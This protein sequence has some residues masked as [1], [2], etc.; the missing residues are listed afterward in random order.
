M[1]KLIE[2]LAS[3]FLLISKYFLSVGS[4]IGWYFSIAGYFFTAWL[5]IK[6]SLRIALIV[7]SGMCVLS[8]YGLYK[9]LNFIKG[10]QPIDLVV[11][12]LVIIF[13][14]FIIKKEI[15]YK[16]PLWFEQS[17]TVLFCSIAYVLLGL[18]YEAIAWFLF[19]IMFLNNMRMYYIKK[20]YMIATVQV[21]S[22]VIAIG[23]LFD[24]DIVSHLLR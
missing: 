2:A 3:I 18:K 22:A 23:K 9:W 11:I 6:L 10:I 19:L 21:L 12:I 24:Y 7:T 15:K 17:I 20:A 14:F 4:I 5:N 16:K 13:S 8:F 1:K